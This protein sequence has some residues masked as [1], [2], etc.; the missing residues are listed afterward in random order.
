MNPARD[1]LVVAAGPR[2]AGYDSDSDHVVLNSA[3]SVTSLLFADASSPQKSTSVCEMSPKCYA[4]TRC[5]I[6]CRV[7]TGRAAAKDVGADR[8]SGA[9]PL[10]ASVQP[11]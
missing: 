5:S 3:A 1:S 10:C 6:S 9:A 2:T 8:P 11:D 7:A 4:A